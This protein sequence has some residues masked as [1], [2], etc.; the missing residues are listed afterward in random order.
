[1]DQVF[2]SLTNIPNQIIFSFNEEIANGMPL[3]NPQRRIFNLGSVDRT[4]PYSEKNFAQRHHPFL[5]PSNGST[6][7]AF[8]KARISFSPVYHHNELATK[9]AHIS[10]I[11]DKSSEIKYSIM[12]FV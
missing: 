10:T 9:Y 7:D 5:A 2:N 4:K 8:F 1:M 11:A 12:R 6:A 3:V